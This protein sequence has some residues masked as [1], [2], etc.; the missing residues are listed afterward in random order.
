MDEDILLS[1]LAVIFKEETTLTQV[2]SVFRWQQNK[3]AHRGAKTP[4]LFLLRCFSFTLTLFLTLSPSLIQISYFWVLGLLPCLVSL[5]PSEINPSAGSG[6]SALCFCLR[7]S[8]CAD[9]FKVSPGW[10]GRGQPFERVSL[11][12]HVFLQSSL[13]FTSLVVFCPLQTRSSLQGPY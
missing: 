13:F 10:E 4:N 12:T 3:L 8:T 2:C 7:Y 11:W 5:V 1:I 9:K 6:P